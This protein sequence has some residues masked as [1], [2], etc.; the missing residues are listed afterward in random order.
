ML[1]N[2]STPT[3]GEMGLERLKP[4]DGGTLPLGGGQWA[5]PHYQTFV[6]FMNMMSRTYWWTFDEALRD[7][8]QNSDAMRN[9]IVI[10]EAL[11]ARYQTVTAM[12][13]MLEPQNKQ[14]QSQKFWAHKLTK[15][16]EE[17]PYIQQFKRNL[18]EAIFFGKY[19]IQPLYKWDYSTGYKRM[20]VPKWYPV[21]GDKIVFKWDG[22]PGILVNPAYANTIKTEYTERGHA[23]FLTP[24]EEEAFIWHE[25]E[26]E[27]AHFYKPEYA[28]TV[29]GTG[30]R[31]RIY[32]WWWLRQNVQRFMMNFLK[33]AGNG[34]VLVGYPSG[35]DPARNAAKTAV[36]GQE[37]NNVIY[38]PT[39]FRDGETIDKVIT[40]VPV[41]MT[42]AQMQWT[43]ITGI[44]ELIKL[45]IKG[46][47]LT[48]EA[49]A[50]GIGSGLGEQHG[51]SKDDRAKY[52]AIDL[53]T[54]MQKLVRN[55][56]KFNCPF[57][58]CPKY[59]HL[60]D[61]RNPK[62]VIEASTTAMDNGLAVP[63]A[64]FRDQLGIPAPI[65]NEPVLTRIQ[66][67]QPTAVGNTPAGVPMAGPGGPAIP[68]G[69]PQ[70]VP[71]QAITNGPTQMSRDYFEEVVK[72]E[73]K[74]DL[75]S[76]RK[77]LNRVP[78]RWNW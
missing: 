58:P 41:H 47:N 28:G 7:S 10:R 52:D 9:D 3:L 53:E 49:K 57:N 54:P 72:L 13:W 11:S 75:E 24:E 35:N 31:G 22:T 4:P 70:Q 45:A 73:M 37:G 1:I 23:H 77:I 39:N 69:P 71:Q 2:G 62:E 20:T 19:G 68:G 30:Y 36:E 29:H 17:I 43:V 5:L 25:F 78:S 8:Q 50:T 59:V 63:E 18:L 33:K 6:S 46:E 74:Q 40:H 34:Y 61:K 76:V 26:P 66:P 64:W 60:A 14:D 51:M 56:N 12:E 67:M 21:H 38:V 55:L 65:G 48:S 42:G 27:D 32:W 16:I 44:N 15:I